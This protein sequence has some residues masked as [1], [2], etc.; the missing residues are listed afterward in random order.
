MQ[1]VRLYASQAGKWVYCPA[2]PRVNNQFK[3][4]YDPQAAIEGTQSHAVAEWIM[5]GR[6]GKMPQATPEGIACAEAYVLRL[7]DGAVPEVSLS[8]ESLGANVGRAK[9]DS[10]LFDNT[11]AD[12]MDYKFGKTPVKAKDNWQLIC[13]CVGVAD[14]YPSISNFRVGIFQPRSN[15]HDERETSWTI[16]RPEVL[17][18]KKQLQHAA[19]RALDPDAMCVTGSHCLWCPG[20]HACPAAQEAA[21]IACNV[22]AERITR[23]LTDYELAADITRLQEA[24]ERLKLRLNGLYAEATQRERI[25]Y[26]EVLPGRS[27]TIWK[28]EPEVILGLLELEGLDIRKPLDLRTPIQTLNLGLSQ[29]LY[30]ELTEVKR[31]ALKLR[32]SDTK[33]FNE[34]IKN[35][36]DNGSATR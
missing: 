34:V 14:R 21:E 30:D 15:N 5:R 26:Y 4:P 22:A 31:G 11:Y 28:Y 36:K 18:Y 33:I 19:R 23:V 10:L 7:P 17:N 24:S 25:P 13:Y 20:L 12:I 27:K 9:V 32:K 16:T 3:S 29:D 1:P 6:V 2:F 8:L 35:V